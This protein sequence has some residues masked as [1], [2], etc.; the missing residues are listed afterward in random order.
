[1]KEELFVII[2][3]ERK[4]LDLNTP[5]G[6]TLNY[7]SNLF[8]D[9]STLNSDH[10]YTFGLPYT[11][12]NRNAFR[13]KE[14][15]RTI[16]SVQVY[17]AEYRMNGV[18]IFNNGE[19]RVEESDSVAGYNAVVVWGESLDLKKLFDKDI[20]LR[21]LGKYNNITPICDI[22]G[23]NKAYDY[24]Y[25]GRYEI[26]P[27][28]TNSWKLMDTVDKYSLYELNDYSYKTALDLNIPKT[29]YRQKPSGFIYDQRDRRTVRVMFGAG[30]G[31]TEGSK[32][33]VWDT[34]W[35]EITSPVIDYLRSHFYSDV[36][37]ETPYP[38]CDTADGL[39]LWGNYPEGATF[40][41]YLVA[42]LVT[43][44]NYLKKYIENAY[45]VTI[46]LPN[47]IRNN[48]CIPF[49]RMGHPVSFAQ[50][51]W[52]RIAVS[53]DDNVGYKWDKSNTPRLFIGTSEEYEA[54]L[55]NNISRKSYH[56]TPESS[57]EQETDIN[58]DCDF[59]TLE[60]NGKIQVWGF[61]TGAGLGYNTHIT[62]TMLVH[63]FFPSELWRGRAHRAIAAMIK[64]VPKLTW[65]AISGEL[66]LE[67]IPGTDDDISAYTT[68]FEVEG[69]ILGY[70]GQG[71][72]I[73]YDMR[74]ASGHL[75][76]ISSFNPLLSEMTIYP[77]I[78]IGSIRV[79]YDE[80][81]EDYLDNSDIGIGVI[82]EDIYV[83]TSN[84]EEISVREKLSLS[85]NTTTPGMIGYFHNLPD[86]SCKDLIN[87]L[88]Y[89]AG[90]FPYY[91]IK[92]KTLK[93]KPWDGLYQIDLKTVDWSNRLLVH[94]AQGKM[95]FNNSG[96]NKKITNVARNIVFQMKN[97]ELDES[98]ELKETQPGEDKYSDS[99]VKVVV[100]NAEIENDFISIQV[101]FNA[102]F[103]KIADSPTLKTGRTFK[104]WKA[105]PAGDIN[106]AI[107]YR[108]KKGLLSEGDINE[109]EP[110]LAKINW[111]EYPDEPNYYYPT[112][113]TWQFDED[114]QEIMSY[115]KFLKKVYEENCVV[116][117]Y[118]QLTEFDLR[119][120]DYTMP[121]YLDKYN[122]YF[123]II[124]IE[125]YDDGVS[126]VTMFKLPKVEDYTVKYEPYIVIMPK[127]GGFDY[128]WEDEVWVS[129]K[130]KAYCYKQN[131][132]EP[133]KTF[134]ADLSADDI[135]VN[136]DHKY[137][138]EEWRWDKERHTVVLTA[139]PNVEQ[140]YHVQLFFEVNV[141]GEAL[142]LSDKAVSYNRIYQ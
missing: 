2:D 24:M 17:V 42:P 65:R 26:S 105:H 118:M 1:M 128:N 81:D 120:L 58:V 49:V 91:D 38:L 63:I 109:A 23:N 52:L 95:D 22:Y 92:N 85:K 46:E 44:V 82:E 68:S 4:Q 5:S 43:P 40:P 8:G 70:S 116:E 124:E 15:L 132:T 103:E 51:C 7:K 84:T 34:T 41:V 14:D 108:Y 53:Y 138:S 54:F 135:K 125:R 59:C 9:I 97:V 127:Q 33:Y 27:A 13:E 114:N 3:G 32:T 30:I 64:N 96:I 36:N 89:A 139:N 57:Y 113:K 102:E 61:R 98:G 122:A 76:T 20:S 107:D 19:L 47:I 88:C 50:Q 78:D 56:Y 75:V 45:D 71:I 126:K 29:Y 106:I 21:D 90:G 93:I 141:R 25:D 28:Y 16:N 99:Y 137:G 133:F 31:L 87:T 134:D 115:T 142:D 79:D 94:G 10:S 111:E 119:D 60:K 48:F 129:L 131:E 101:P 67:T 117:E 66:V 140:S 73:Y 104:F 123:G 18:V 86:I 11:L 80:D 83:Y 37:R 121:V 35:R 6:I 110:I 72:D 112:I 12:N 136:F 100:D 55:V 39:G 69:A 74:E 62:G 77:I 130:I